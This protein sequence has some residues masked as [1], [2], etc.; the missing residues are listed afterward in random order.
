MSICPNADSW[1]DRLVVDL[2]N[3]DSSIEFGSPHPDTPLAEVIAG[4]S[5]PVFLQ[6]AAEN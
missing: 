1:V 6:A 2:G 4:P 5:D 3:Y